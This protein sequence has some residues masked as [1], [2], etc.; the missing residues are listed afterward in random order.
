MTVGLMRDEAQIACRL[1]KKISA[2]PVVAL[3]YRGYL[4][5]FGMTGWVM[6]VLKGI[7][8]SS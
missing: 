3:S 6:R 2:M 8:C 5:S 7:E 1:E 4:T